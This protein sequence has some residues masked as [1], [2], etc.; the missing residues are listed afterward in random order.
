MNKARQVAAI[1]LRE[2]LYRGKRRLRI[3][4]VGMPNSGKSTL[5]SAVSS[6]SIRTGELGGTHRAYN[7]CAVQIGLDEARV[8]ELP[9]IQ[10]LHDLPPDDLVALQYLLWGDEPPPV[11]VHE[12]GGPP[13]PFAPPDV[14]IQVIDA[15]AL[16]RHLELT[17]ELSQLGR[18][19]VIAL[20][21][22]DEAW[23]KGLH[24]NARGVEPAVGHSGGADGGADGAGH[25]EAV[26][27]GRRGGAREGLPAA[28]A[29]EQAPLRKAPAPEPGAQPA[30]DPGGVPRAASAAGHAAGAERR[31]LPRR[32]A[33]ALSRADAATAAVARRGRENPAA[34]ARRGAAR[35]PASPRRHAVRV[36]D[37]PRR[38]ARRPRL[39]LLAR[40]TV[41]AS[42]VGPAREPRGVRRRAVRGLRGQRLDRLPDLG[43]AGRVDFG[44]AAAIDRRRDR[45]RG[46]GR[47]HR[48]GRH[49][50]AVHDPA[51]AAAGGAGGVR[52]HAA[53][54]LRRGPRLP[55]P[56]PARRGRGAVPDRARLQRAGAFRG[57][58]R[59]PRPRAPHRL[60]ADH[61]RAMLGALRHHPRARR[62]ISRRPRCVRDLPAEHDRD[63]AAGEGC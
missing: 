43:Q 27:D 46:G 56:R 62:Q 25:R 42:A 30:G 55:P 54:R 11:K 6:T 33:A 2:P 61:L 7:E 53:H 4:L 60:A 36:G 34:P 38:P 57:V 58:P 18:P 49:R 63:R 13:A 15:T 17:L 22:M 23:K 28:A 14:I 20:N 29:G 39:A 5:F 50:R 21:M 24:I 40:R 52:D 51:G 9:S 10:T 45:A 44:V 3:A 12:P 48:P 1:P 32:D 8:V 35:R 16:A 26:Q 31:L 47:P 19:M 59:H 41:P 37:P